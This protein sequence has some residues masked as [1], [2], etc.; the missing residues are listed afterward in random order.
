MVTAKAA[1]GGFMLPRA[2]LLPLCIWACLHLAALPG[3][4][5]ADPYVPPGAVE[6][7]ALP[8]VTS[9]PAEPVQ[10]P[11]PE[12][13]EEE[14]EDPP[15]PDPVVTALEAIRGDAVQACARGEELAI[16]QAHRIW[17][18]VA[19]LVAMQEEQAQL[20]PLLEQ[21]DAKFGEEG[22]VDQ[23]LGAIEKALTIGGGLP[24]EVVGYP[25]PL[26]VDAGEVV[27]QGEELEVA[28][29]ELLAAVRAGTETDNQNLWG[30]AG[31]AAGVLALF[32]LYRMVRP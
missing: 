4:A 14:P 12:E 11:P 23:R 28:D 18:L 6:E 21:L 30:I 1:R 20:V 3:V 5:L 32:W 15:T 2:V 7:P 9:C 17:W 25:E 13:P 19:E 26:S 16:E 24:V 8:G 29:E 10:E 22:R 27:L 31:L